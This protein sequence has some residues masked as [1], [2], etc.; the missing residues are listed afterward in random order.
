MDFNEQAVGA[1]GNG[2]A[3][4]R[5]NFVALAGSV[6]GINK[7]RQVAA[8]LDGGEDGEVERVVGKIGKSSK[9]TVTEHD[10]IIGLGVV[11]IGRPTEFCDAPGNAAVYVGL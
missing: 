2:G 6:A 8:L 4:K 3:G 9:P 5:Q 10:V 11:G 1:N 7:D